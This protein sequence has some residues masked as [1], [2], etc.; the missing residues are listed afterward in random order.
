MP[1]ND[2]YDA[3]ESVANSTYFSFNNPTGV[4]GMYPQSGKSNVR[5]R[6]NDS[7]VSSDSN[8]RWFLMGFSVWGADAEGRA[9][10]V[11]E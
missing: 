9:D 4:I 6:A 2:M 10:I 1:I 5:T 3:I 8:E 11:G 7:Y